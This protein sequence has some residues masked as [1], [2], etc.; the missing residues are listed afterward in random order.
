MYLCIYVYIRHIRE[1][2]QYTQVNGNNIPIS[3]TL[4]PLVRK[5]KNFTFDTD[6]ERD[7]YVITTPRK[8]FFPLISSKRLC[9]MQNGP[10]ELS[11]EIRKVIIEVSDNIFP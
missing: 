9:L 8:D 6:S 5:S 10:I 2:R 4:S 7:I 3:D 1:L 11:K